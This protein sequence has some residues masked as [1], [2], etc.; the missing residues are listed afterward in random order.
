MPRTQV[1]QD[2]LGSEVAYKFLGR[3]SKEKISQ[4]FKGC[5]SVVIRSE[6]TGMYR[7]E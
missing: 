6:N 2:D 3:H 1:W 7:E 4:V 5:V